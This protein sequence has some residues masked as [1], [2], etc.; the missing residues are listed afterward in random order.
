MDY[1]AFGQGHGALDT[2][3]RLARLA[4]HEVGHWLN[5]E[6]IFG[7]NVGGCTASDYVNDTP[8]QAMFNTGNPSFPQVTCPVQNPTDGDMFM[9]HMDY[10]D[11]KSKLMF[12]RD[13]A[14]RMQAIFGPGGYRASLKSSPALT[15]V[16]NIS[17]AGIPG[18]VF[19][20]D[21]TD[22]NFHPSTNAVGCGGGYIAYQWTATNGWTV[23]YPD[24]FYP[25]IIP[26]G[27][28]SSVI[29]L[30]GTYTN[31]AG[32]R[33]PLNTANVA[34]GFNP[35]LPTPVF[36]TST[37]NRTSMCSGTGGY[38]ALAVE[39]VAG[40]SSYNWTV[41]PGFATSG[42]LNTNSLLI[43]PN[44]TLAGGVY[45]VS[46]Q[47]Q[48]G[49]C[50]PSATVSWSFIANGGPQMKIVDVNATQNFQGIVCARNRLFL[51][52]APRTPTPPG[53]SWYSYTNILWSSGRQTATDKDPNF[54]LR[55]TYYTDAA[56][57]W[58]FTVTATY[59]DP[60]GN[61][62]KNAVV[63]SARTALAP[64][65]SLGNGYVCAP[66]QWRSVPSAPYPN[67]ATGALQL[68]GY[69]GSVVVYNQQGKEI[70]R[71]LAP[72]TDYGAAVDTSTWPDGLYVVT[73]RN[74]RGEFMRH[75]VQ[76]R[77]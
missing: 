49:C 14:L 42:P 31:A 17:T 35:A 63:Y 32:I 40:A 68:P 73:G 6:H 61:I 11:D 23:N 77:H 10:V 27:I 1:R 75:N 41:P 72:G 67:P 52:L 62:G 25:E 26:S 45:A 60:C 65:T 48:G 58:P 34:V 3:Y 18:T 13:Q 39:P 5:L 20:G 21:Q 74:L 4:V 54:P 55:A 22:Y 9:N 69:Q 47:A 33:F 51:E 28:G 59:N 16:L 46:C 8:P 7:S 57:N 56:T 64:G 43:T 2:R 30:T 12:S 19:C 70:H 71:L 37:T 76:V 50:A 44:A 66:N 29:T 36:T 24:S 53:V 38:Y 15:P